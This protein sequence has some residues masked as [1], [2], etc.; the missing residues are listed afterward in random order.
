M[1]GASVAP[2]ATQLRIAA[3]DRPG[4][5]IARLTRV[6]SRIG[7][8]VRLAAAGLVL[9]LLAAGS[10]WG[11]DDHFPVG[12]FV[13]YAFTAE[14]DG[15]VHSV[16]IEVVD[17]RGH[18]RPLT[19]TPGTVGLRRAEVEGQ[20]PRLVEHPRLLRGLA[21]AHHRLHPRAPRYVRIDVVL[22]TVHLRDGRAERRSARLLASWREP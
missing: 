2:G 6:L 4:S 3:R 21:V 17:E 9:A 16:E 1:I 12:P 20:L 13:M 22:R 15:E 14:P 8:S 7:R 19:P 5:R 18:R 10:L 11:Q